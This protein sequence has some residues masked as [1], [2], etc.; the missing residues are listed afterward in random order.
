[1]ISWLQKT[2]ASSAKSIP[3]K[4]ASSDT[5]ES[6]A[7]TSNSHLPTEA[8][9]PSCG[10]F[11]SNYG[12]NMMILFM[13]MITRTT[14]KVIVIEIKMIKSMVILLPHLLTPINIIFIISYLYHHHSFISLS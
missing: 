5:N 8:Y 4:P 2:L 7:G 10:G 9:N 3:Y 13:M 6:V 1:M 11:N 14:K 12:T